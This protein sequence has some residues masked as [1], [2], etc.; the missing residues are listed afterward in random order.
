MKETTFKDILQD[1]PPGEYLNVPDVVYE[2][3]QGMFSDKTIIAIRKPD[4]HLHCDSESCKGVRLFEYNQFPMHY[5]HREIEYGDTSYDHVYIEYLCQNC[6]ENVKSFAIIVLNIHEDKSTADIIKF[7]E[8]PFYGPHIPSKLISLIGPDREIFI[9]GL[10]CESQKFGIAAFAYYRRVIENQKERLI[11]NISKVLSNL[12]VDKSALELLQNAKD[13]NQFKTSMD[14]L[15]PYLPNELLIDNYNPLVLLH[16]SLS[17]GLH[18]LS[19]DE[20]LK[21]ARSIRLVLTELSVRLKALL[22][23]K[24]ELQDALLNLNKLKG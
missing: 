11:D 2:T 7:G 4:L 21:H 6:K 1:L 17:I 14:K 13:E 3:T 10:K 18:S 8:F 23:D 15:K 9:K 16:K 5:D 19:D 24:K 22:S 12:N 20:C